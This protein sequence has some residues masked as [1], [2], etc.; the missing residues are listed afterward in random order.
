MN[1]RAVD[2]NP[3]AE[4]EAYVSE[5]G[6]GAGVRSKYWNIQMPSVAVAVRVAEI[7]QM[8]YKSGVEDNQHKIQ[9]ALGIERRIIT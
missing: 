3:F 9:K 5:H 8:A 7:I 2:Y 4:C 6:T 1:D